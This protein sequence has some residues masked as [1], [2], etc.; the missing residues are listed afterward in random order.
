[1]KS[2]ARIAL[3]AAALTA[4]FA[5][6]VRAGEVGLL[7]DQQTGNSVPLASGN[8]SAI[9]PS[10]YGIRGGYTILNLHVAELGLDATYHPKTQT[11]FTSGG[12]SDKLGDDYTSVGVQADWTL[13]LNLHAGLDLRREVLSQELVGGTTTYTR[14]WAN[15][16]IG[17]SLPLPVLKPFIRVEAAWATKTTS[18]PAAGEVTAD[19]FRKAAAPRYQIGLYGGLRF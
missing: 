11:S 16:G 1:M 12:T 10:G 15:A 13:L 9:K 7:L 19:Q 8:V 17:F 2:I 14:P 6:P 3:F 18:L 4:I 5:L